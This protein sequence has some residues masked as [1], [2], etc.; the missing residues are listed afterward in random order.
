MPKAPESECIAG[1]R[2]RDYV[3]AM[4]FGLDISPAGEWGDP[5]TIAEL[6]ALAERSGWDGVFLEDY[7]FY[8]GGIDAYDPWVAL[9]LIAAATDR[10][11]IGPMVTP[12]PRRRPWKVAAEAMTVD[13]LSGGR[14]VLGAGSGDPQSADATRVGEERDPVTRGRM[15]D[16]ALEI[17]A[18]LWRGEAVTY[19][20][21]HYHLQ[22]VSLR[23][24]PVARPRPPIW[25]G[26]QLTRRGPRARALRWDGACLYRIAPP[27]WE[28]VT[29]DDLRALRADADARVSGTPFTIVVGGRQRRDDEAA[30]VEYVRSIAAAG[31]DWWQEYVPPATP[32]AEARERIERGPLRIA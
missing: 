31:A 32:E 11:L 6:A 21:Q 5:R 9:A 19:H 4:Q 24:S 2:T 3:G 13:R 7:V 28:D 16:E 26:G 27:E 25:I 15:L 20:G 30:E 17:I 22:D 12:L 29:P 14:L 1:D 18:A 23:P 10:V 8:P